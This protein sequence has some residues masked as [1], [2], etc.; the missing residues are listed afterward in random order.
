MNAAHVQIFYEGAWYPWC[1]ISSLYELGRDAKK[2]C[3]LIELAHSQNISL[4]CG[5]ESLADAQK[6]MA[7]L[8]EHRPH[9]K[10]RA[11]ETC[12]D[13]PRED[14]ANAE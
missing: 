14:F 6:M 13:A 12:C 10:L 4:I 3:Q 7:F 9:L 5:H 2:Q 8:A 1:E 11:V